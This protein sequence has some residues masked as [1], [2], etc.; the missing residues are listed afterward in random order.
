M[1]NIV[2]N[3]TKALLRRGG[4]AASFSVSRLRGADTPGIARAC[5]FPWLFIDQEHNPIA[6]D[7]TADMCAAALA[8]GVTPI[9]RV[10]GHEH[11]H[12]SRALDAGAQGVVVPHIDTVE[13]ARAVVRACMYPPAGNRSLT[14]ALPQLGFQAPSSLADAMQAMNAETLVVVMLETEAALAN[15]DAIAAVEGVDVL[16]I[17]SNDLAADLGI[18]GDFRH[19]RIR[20]AYRRVTDACRAAGKFAGMGGIYDEPLMRD[21]VEAG[22]RFLLGGSDVAFMMA[23]AK[24]RAT[25][26]R[27]LQPAGL[28]EAA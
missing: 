13:E 28:E 21:Y 27:T 11:H 25:F 7:T 8:C 1:S 23:A 4:V 18:P 17:G 19:P 24:Q 3:R 20:E 6:L 10:P 22:V 5:G 26:V 9:V 15:A 2:P 16:M 12:I 14:G